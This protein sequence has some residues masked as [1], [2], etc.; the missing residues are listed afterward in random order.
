MLQAGLNK[1]DPAHPGS[2]HCVGDD[3]IGFLSK[4]AVGAFTG[5]R[6][7]AAG[8]FAGTCVARRNGRT[9]RVHPTILQGFVD[10]ET[11]KLLQDNREH[12]AQ[13]SGTP[14]KARMRARRRSAQVLKVSATPV[15]CLHA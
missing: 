6:C 4:S 13:H 5:Q 10:F 8:A 2:N 12:R 14:P 9:L 15:G 11:S 3:N 1:L 7:L